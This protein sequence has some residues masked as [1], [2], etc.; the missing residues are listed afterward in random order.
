MSWSAEVP[1]E[2]EPE[3]EPDEAEWAAERG[4]SGGGGTRREC[5]CE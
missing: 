2:P 4:P 1:A 3:P 5:A